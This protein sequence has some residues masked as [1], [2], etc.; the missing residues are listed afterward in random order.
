MSSAQ[1][2]PLPEE[3]KQALERDF[4]IRFT[5]RGRRT[6]EFRTTETTF[7]WPTVVE[8]PGLIYVS[9]YPGKRDWVAN[10]VAHPEVIIHTVERGLY[11]DIPATARVISDRN[12][13]TDPLLAFLDRWANRP[14]AK[15]RVFG[16]IV[17]AIRL[18]RRLHL[19][20]WGPFYLARRIMD[21]MPCLELTFTGSPIRTGTPPPAAT[22]QR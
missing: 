6:G 19:P 21:R 2:Y 4:F 5:T 17:A 15:Q 14:E 8:Q 11:Y 7:V 3:L 1:Q 10:A 13:R 20:W 16:W 9:G 18:N 12:E 22:A